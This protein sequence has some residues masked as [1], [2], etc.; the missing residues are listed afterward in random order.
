VFWCKGEFCL[1]R[2]NYKYWLLQGFGQ[3]FGRN[4]VLS[5]W[6]GEKGRVG[7][8]KTNVVRDPCGNKRVITCSRVEFVGIVVSS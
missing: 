4:K 6:F 1:T 8:G 5:V 2:R 3:D 7:S